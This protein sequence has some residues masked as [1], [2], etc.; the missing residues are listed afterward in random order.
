MFHEEQF[1][2]SEL[3]FSQL[4]WLVLTSN[5]Y[6]YNNK[7]INSVQISTRHDRSYPKWLLFLVVYRWVLRE[8]ARLEETLCVVP[9]P[10]PAWFPCFSDNTNQKQF[11]SLVQ[12]KM[13]SLLHFQAHYWQKIGKELKSRQAARGRNWSRGHV[14]VLLT[15]LLLMVC[16]SAFNTVQEHEPR[17]GTTHSELG[18]PATII[19]HEN[20]PSDLP[21]VRS[22]STTW[23]RPKVQWI[24]VLSLPWLQFLWLGSS[25]EIAAL[26][27]ESLRYGFLTKFLLLEK[28]AW[29]SYAALPLT[30]LSKV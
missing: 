28:H 7:L 1:C 12:K 6:I 9:R 17:G 10:V 5:N 27:V 13:V 25:K 30:G 23:Q 8:H 22:T 24:T 19:N 2:L 29:L 18:P 15:G 26:Q 11:V 21:I 4:N 3:P 14:G 16:S 20:A